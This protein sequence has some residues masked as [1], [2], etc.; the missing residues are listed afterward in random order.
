MKLHRT[1][2]VP[3]S[4]IPSSSVLCS[5]LITGSLA[6]IRMSPIG[7]CA[8]CELIDCVHARS[9]WEFV[10]AGDHPAIFCSI[11]TVEP[12][13]TNRGRAWLNHVRSGDS[14]ARRLVWHQYNDDHWLAG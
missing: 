1:R 5:H 13:K 2:R 3:L 4:L 7:S 6:I 11:A 10:L 14:S 8:S 9:R 12:R